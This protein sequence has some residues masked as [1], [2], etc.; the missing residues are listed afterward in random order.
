M[1]FKRP[2]YHEDPGRLARIALDIILIT[3]LVS[4]TAI[5]IGWMAVH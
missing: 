2:H 4:G 3:S 5:G 1:P